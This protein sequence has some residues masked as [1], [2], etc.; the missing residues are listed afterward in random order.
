MLRPGA[1]DQ[2]R[3]DRLRR[4]QEFRLERIRRGRVL[5]V[6]C[7]ALGNEAAKDLALAGL[8]QLDLVDPDHVVSSN[9]PRCVLFNEEDAERHRNKAEAMRRNLRRLAPGI[10]SAAFRKAIEELPDDFVAR[11]DLVLGGL[12]NL[13]A[14]L[15]I[16]AR[17]W[18][19]RRP[20]IDGALQGLIGKVQVVRPPRGACLECGM[21]ATH[22]KI[23]AQRFSCS[24][25]E[26]TF[27]EPI[28]PAEITTTSLIGAVMAQE[29]LKLLSGRPELC[30]ENLFY[31]DGRRNVAEVL[32]VPRNPECALHWRQRPGMSS[33][34]PARS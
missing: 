9:L 11:Y 32:Q 8:R 16:N 27:V 7:G 33:Y 24:G 4:V 14:R 5:L 15:H 2:D 1:F 12:D 19:A 20:Y 3:F 29:A 25:K 18:I 10:K 17:A 30:L 31:F 21:N 34:P 13:A 23:V 6:G 28:V 26:F 22:A